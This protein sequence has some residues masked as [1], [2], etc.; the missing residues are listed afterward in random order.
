MRNRHMSDEYRLIRIAGC[1]SQRSEKASLLINR[2]VCCQSAHM[3]QTST[4]LAGQQY[5]PSHPTPCP[6]NALWTPTLEPF[7]TCVLAA[8]ALAHWYEAHLLGRQRDV[9]TTTRVPKL[10][11]QHP[12]ALVRVVAVRLRCV[13][14]SGCAQKDCTAVDV[15]QGETASCVFE[16]SV[17]LVQ[18]IRLQVSIL[19]KWCLNVQC[20][21]GCT[22]VEET[23]WLV[24]YCEH[25]VWVK[26]TLFLP[27]KIFHT[28][29][30]DYHYLEHRLR[31]SSRSRL[32]E[33]LD[34]LRS[35]YVVDHV[36]CLEEDDVSVFHLFHASQDH[37]DPEVRDDCSS[38]SWSSASIFFI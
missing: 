32:Y 31:V 25:T 9:P 34:V 30:H 11:H 2:W 21:C 26:W 16:V 35:S 3:S 24:Q 37:D 18:E 23:R 5:H 7:K 29:Q 4:I 36:Y 38:E 12:I 13:G 1:E 14:G 19:S 28:K 6:P 27:P 22:T 10:L 8:T 15:P 17:A 33:H 20:Q